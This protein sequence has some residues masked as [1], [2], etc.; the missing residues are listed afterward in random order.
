MNE[1]REVSA[2]LKNILTGKE[3]IELWDKLKN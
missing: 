2:Q 3:R 1:D